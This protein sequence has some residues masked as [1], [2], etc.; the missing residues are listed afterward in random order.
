MRVTR[1]QRGY[2][3][4]YLLHTPRPG[5]RPRILYWYRTA[6][7]VRVGRRALDEDA[8]RVLEE[9]HPDIDFDWPALLEEAESIE[10][11]VE[12]RPERPR[13]RKAS[14]EG[15]EIAEKKASAES[16]EG[17][18]KRAS[19]E[20]SQAAAVPGAPITP[21]PPSAPSA[22]SAPRRNPLL[23]QLVGRE[24]AARLRGRYADVSA[25]LAELPD[26]DRRRAWQARADALDP[27]RWASAE[28]ILA[29][30]QHADRLFD[31]LKR[32]LTMAE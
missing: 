16:A 15:A 18:E 1:D 6:P 7:G 29:G 10:P 3:T 12:R 21:I 9:Q 22:P 19:A 27:D 24:I 31:E 13:K 4:T 20:T 26:D 17:A 11:E 8:I 28:A 14:A 32:E 30:I 5:D 2:E 25:R 23:D